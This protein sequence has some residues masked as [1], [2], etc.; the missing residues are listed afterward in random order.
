MEVPMVNET[1]VTYLLQR[2]F[3][4]DSFVAYWMCNRPFG[5]LEKYIITAPPFF[6]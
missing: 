1:A 6:L 4:M 3:Q 2:G 5:K